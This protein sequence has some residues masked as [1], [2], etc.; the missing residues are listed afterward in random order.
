MRITRKVKRDRY[1]R[2]NVFSDVIKT[3]CHYFPDFSRWL[4]S[5]SDPRH[6][7]YIKYDQSVIIMERLLA[8]CCH[9]ESMRAMNS[10][11][12]GFNNYNVINNFS[13]IFNEELDELPH[14]DTINN[15]LKEVDVDEFRKII[16]NMV[17]TLIKKRVF[18]DYRIDNKYYHFLIDAS[19]LHS[20]GI[21]HTPGSL[22]T[23][24]KSGEIT[25]H[26]DVLVA[27]I[28]VGNMSVPVD[29]EW[30]E[31]SPTGYTKQDC[32][33][34]AAKRL[35]RR[36]KKA[37]KKLNICISGDALYL[38][39]PI[40]QI[41]E[42]NNWKYV[43]RYKNDVI[44]Y[45]DE[46]LQVSMEHNDIVKRN[47]LDKDNKI[48]QY[49]YYNGIDYRGHMV[50]I[51]QLSESDEEGKEMQ[52]AFA[53]NFEITDKNYK[54]LIEVGRHRWKIENKTFNDLKNHGYNIEHVFCYDDN[55]MKAHFAIQLISHLIMQLLE[56][57]EK[58]KEVFE[59]I[60]ALGYSIKEALRSGVL[61]AKNLRDITQPFQIRKEISY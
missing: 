16:S 41:C 32:E 40:I 27:S 50:N 12:I 22:V 36:L 44:P 24:H 57:Y 49:E 31:N 54:D 11:I 25:Y 2:L 37:L 10:E 47:D 23:H 35:L 48:Q 6:Q 39:E 21:E 19:Q 26:N 20:S 38:C 14:G 3:T 61:N 9:I 34:K 52:F 59:T 55:A 4:S 1:S 58:T 7:S 46:H 15:Y 43:I 51:V 56:H 13:I 8:S 28:V 53:T 30:L 45:I 60:K 18:E 17:K 42:D 33:L 29:F 5:I